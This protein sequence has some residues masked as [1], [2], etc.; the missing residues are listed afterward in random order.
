MK[1]VIVGAG[2]V[3]LHLAKTLSWQEYDVSIID[4]KQSLVD[5]AAGSLDVMAI[6]GSGTSI[7]TLLEAGVDDADLLIAVTS[8]DEVNIVAC[9]LAKQLGAKTR[10]ARVRN[11]EYSSPDVPINLAELGIDQIIHPELEAAREV[12]R[13]I[14]Y[15]QAVDIVECAG[16]KMM[17]V[18]FKITSNSDIIK[19]PLMALTPQYP[20]ISLRIVAIGRGAETIIPSGTDVILPDDTIYIM[21][22]QRNLDRVFQMAGKSGNVSFDVMLLGGGLVGRLVAGRLEQDKRFNIKLIES[23]K[24]RSQIAAE[25]LENTIVVRGDEEMD[26]DLMVME[27]IEE[28]GVFAA[29]SDDDENNIVTSLF[30]RHMRVPRTITL[31]TKPEYSPIARAIGLDA[32]VNELILTSDAILKHLLGARILAVATLRGIEADIVE[33]LVAAG[34]KAAGLKLKETSFPKGAIIGAIEHLGEVVV[35]EGDSVIYAGDT[36]VAFCI[37]DTIPELEKLFR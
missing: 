16:G 14:R 30:A 35:A 3:G 36:L 19:K 5:R 31:S 2:V 21:T 34:S 9:V 7:K 23:D 11:Q 25:T 28:M 18:G 22:H 20:D 17:L 6:R 15:H 24:D 27:G 13:M 12:E 29:L 1:I 37:P 4:R 10:I 33:F 8:I 26:I 32:A